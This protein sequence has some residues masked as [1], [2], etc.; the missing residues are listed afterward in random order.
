MTLREVTAAEGEWDRKNSWAVLKHWSVQMSRNW[1]PDVPRRYHDILCLLLS[2]Q[3]KLFLDANRVLHNYLHYL[4]FMF[5]AVC[6]RLVA[7]RCVWICQ[8]Q[9]H[10]ETLR[11]STVYCILLWLWFVNFRCCESFAVE[12]MKQD[13]YSCSVFLVEYCLANHHWCPIAIFNFLVHLVG[14]FFCYPFEGHCIHCVVG[15]R[16]IFV[17]ILASLLI[18]SILPLCN[19]LW[20]YCSRLQRRCSRH[21][22]SFCPSDCSGR[23]FYCCNQ[24]CRCIRNYCRHDWLCSIVVCNI[25]F[26]N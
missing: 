14:E 4:Q 9:S 21:Y 3:D 16:I 2:F 6:E 5:D 11:Q 19:R 10:G 20:R 15:N 13:W 12:D 26:G 23:H 18:Y 25:R 22:G 8:V 17:A 7:Y 1:L 24:R